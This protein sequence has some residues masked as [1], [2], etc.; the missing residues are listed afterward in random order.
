MT[1]NSNLGH[2]SLTFV[3]FCLYV[4]FLTPMTFDCYLLLISSVYT[5]EEIKNN[6]YPAVLSRYSILEQST[7]HHY[8]GFKTLA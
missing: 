4:L 3:G 7:M 1:Y 8:P 6:G 2:W 5:I